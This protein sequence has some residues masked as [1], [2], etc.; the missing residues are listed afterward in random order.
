MYT[1]TQ[2]KKLWRKET[3]DLRKQKSQEYLDSQKGCISKCLWIAGKYLA[4]M[5]I[6]WFLIVFFF[7]WGVLAPNSEAYEGKITYEKLLE[8]STMSPPFRIYHQLKDECYSQ[9]VRDKWHCIETWLAIAYAE[10]SWRDNH[11]P[12]GL[13]SKE[14]W[15]KKWVR[16]YNKY[17]YKSKDAFFFY[18]DWGQYGRSHYCTD[19]HSSWSTKGCPNGRK[20]AQ[21]VLDSLHIQ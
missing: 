4:I 17:W 1:K 5:G 2:A 18:W 9:N 7:G 6:V 8:N 16:S 15:Y 21:I 11:T 13:Q 19:E 14:K 3:V 12:F 20:N 10:S